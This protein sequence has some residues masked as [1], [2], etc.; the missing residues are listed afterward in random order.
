MFR[1]FLL[2]VVFMPL[3]VINGTMATA[4]G[5]EDI[6]NR[7]AEDT[8]RGHLI[9]HYEKLEKTTGQLKTALQTFCLAPDVKGLMTVRDG[10]R[11]TVIAFGEIDHV[12]F[13]PITERYRRE[14]FYYWPDRKGR[15]A[16]AVRRL[17]HAKDPSALTAAMLA[18]KSVAVQ[19]LGALEL[20]IFTKRADALLASDEQGRFNCGYALAIAEN[21]Q[22][23][24]QSLVAGWTSNSGIAGLMTDPKP[25]AE[26][27]RSRKE[28]VQEI[29]QSITTGFKML[30]DLN[31]APV[32]GSSIAKA[33]PKRAAF[34]LSGY[35]LLYLKAQFDG[36]MVFVASSGFIKLLPNSQVDLLAHVKR[37]VD[38][39]NDLFDQLSPNGQ[40][41]SMADITKDPGRR[42][43]FETIA[44]KITHLN[45][46]FARQFAVAA[47]LPLGFNA[48]D[49]D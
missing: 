47:D 3:L 15:G 40:P 10:F 38:E 22:L 24:S 8:I 32:L 16:R 26:R 39:I 9:P 12:H 41:L 4:Q 31:F 25:T 45:A 6:L 36:L 43:I 35:S 21:L 5:H 48:T 46:G 13:G 42:V 44:T 2:I 37:V 17:L 29:Y 34:R 27:Y 33:K 49:G 19:G 18:R 28:V 14:R 1:M 20:V 7:M 11:A 23:I 30:T